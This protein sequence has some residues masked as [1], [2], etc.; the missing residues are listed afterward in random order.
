MTWPAG[1]YFLPTFPRMPAASPLSIGI[2][3]SKKELVCALRYPHHVRHITKTNTKVGIRSLDSHFKRCT[4][5]IVMESTGRYHFLPALLLSGQGYDIRIVNPIITKRYM[6][7][8]VRNIKSD[9]TDATALAQM[10]LLDLK[11]PT[12]FTFAMSDIVLRQKIGLLSKLEKKL[13]SLRMMQREYEEVCR[14]CST[15]LSAAEIDMKEQIGY[16]GHA[17]EKLA[18]EIDALV[19]ADATMKR[20]V[21]LLVTIPGVSHELATILCAHLSMESTHPKQWIAFVGLDVTVR[22]SGNWKGRG[23][24]SKRGN[25]YLRKRLYTAAWGAQM[26]DEAFDAAYQKLRDEGRTYREA[27][28]ILSRKILRIAFAVC[29]KEQPYHPESR[30]AC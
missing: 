12:P 8:S 18:G 26:N 7:S 20:R 5:P 21:D 30:R 27:I 3:V 10:A 4:C 24:L 23:K 17:Q 16:L 6:R 19:C 15:D 29:K 22:Q 13:Q 11:L 9:P 1:P 25:P 14:L 28:V 2:D